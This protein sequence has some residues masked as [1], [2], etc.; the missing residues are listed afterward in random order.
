MI[1]KT[2]KLLNED[3]I[4]ITEIGLLPQAPHSTG[5]KY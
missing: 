5:V 4:D 1:N 3:R 2:F